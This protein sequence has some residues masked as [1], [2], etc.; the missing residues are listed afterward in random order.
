[1]KLPLEPP[2]ATKI[3]DFLRLMQLVYEKEC[4]EE[5]KIIEEEENPS[6][7]I[8]KKCN[9]RVCAMVQSSNPG[10]V[11]WQVYADHPDK[12]YKFWMSGKV[13]PELLNKAL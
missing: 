11:C 13:L 3:L 1:M 10:L 5:P 8:C 4:L 9:S 7:S 2:L 6:Q 12:V